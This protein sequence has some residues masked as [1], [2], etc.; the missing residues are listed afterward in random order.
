MNELDPVL[1]IDLVDPKRD[2]S[3]LLADTDN[4]FGIGLILLSGGQMRV[5]TLGKNQKELEILQSDPMPDKEAITFAGQLAN[6][7]AEERARRLG[8]EI[9]D[10]KTEIVH[11]LK[12]AK[13]DEPAIRRPDQTEFPEDEEIRKSKQYLRLE[14][15]GRRIPLS[16]IFPN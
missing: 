9:K 16:L 13:P 10:E 14:R 3:V 2:S 11:V 4:E 8:I 1:N 15:N 5:L 12:D 7:W 6:K